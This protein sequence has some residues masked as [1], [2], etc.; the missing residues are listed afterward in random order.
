MTATSIPEAP[1]FAAQSERTVWEALVEQLPDEA[2]ILV[3][4]RI[5][6]H[7]RE[8]E[9]DLLVFWPE[10]GVV[11]LEVKGGTVSVQD[12][13]WFQSDGS[14]RR[15]LA[16]S[17]IEQVRQAKHE[18]SE[19]LKPR[20]SFGLG[21]ITHVV[22]LPY[23]QAPPKW[24]VPD[25]PRHLVAFAQ[26]V[27][28]LAG[29]LAE[30]LRK[31]GASASVLTEKQ[32]AVVLKTLRAT[33]KAVENAQLR[34]QEITD[35]GNQLTREQE[36]VL[37]L[38][39]FQHRAQLIGGA[40]S[41]KTHLAL[42]KARDQVRAGKRVALVCYSRG[43]ARHF[44]LT[45]AGWPPEERPQFVG[46]FHDLPVLLGAEEEPE[47]T[48]EEIAQY[49]DEVLPRRLAELAALLPDEHRFEAIVVDEAQDFAD[50]WWEGLTLCLLGGEDGELFVFADAHQKVFDREGSSP[51][52]L[53][54]FPLD[55]NLRNTATIAECFAPLTPV[56]QIARMDAGVP[57][58][59]VPV[60]AGASV[61]EAADDQVE[62]MLDAG[63]SPGDVAL[64]TTGR[65]HGEQIAQVEAFGPAGY[66]D[67]FFA[68]DEVFYGH[69]LGFKGLERPVVVLALNDDP[70]NAL[71]TQK[72]YVGLSRARSELVVVGNPQDLLEIGGDEVFR[73]VT[74]A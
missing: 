49:Y 69:V 52:T 21:R 6:D 24:A 23:T 13:E 72:L 51:I 15:A 32:T 70:D 48:R 38:L 26:D 31:Q 20:V 54:P 65:R 27:E 25:V 67:A 44:E 74:G 5:T 29:F 46:L 2:T 50:S 30:A 14:G 58:R 18:L 9:I 53:S 61:T 10:V 37:A 3:G 56:E 33:H 45:V 40:G 36:K 73:R 62:A 68:G 8:V 22:V 4:Q 12:G 47:G 66:W 63:W 41:G 60:A 34:S 19:F 7:A 71:A 11:A 39:R 16:K 28:R 1:E 59:F 43:L 42:M 57:V 64:L 55:D 17:P 35:T